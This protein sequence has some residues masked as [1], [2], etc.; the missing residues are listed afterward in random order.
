MNRNEEI[1]EKLYSYIDIYIPPGK[2]QATNP[3][4]WE[5]DEA[6]GS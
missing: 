1:K 4:I 6:G 3:S 5:A 2:K